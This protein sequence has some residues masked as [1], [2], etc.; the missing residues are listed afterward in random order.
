MPS[1]APFGPNS[2]LVQ[3][4]FSRLTL[5]TPEEVGIL[6]AN[7]RPSIDFL[8]AGATAWKVA[9]KTKLTAA[10]QNAYD[11]PF[12]IVPRQHPDWLAAIS[13]AANAAMA[14]ALGKRLPV[15]AWELLMASVLA[16]F[17]DWKGRTPA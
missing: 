14:L 10:V 5:A 16:A 9:R 12:S 3:N 6:A 1:H 8:A 11:A 4:F 17:P 13:S 7:W 2:S 15:P